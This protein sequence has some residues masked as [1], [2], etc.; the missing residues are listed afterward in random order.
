LL[1]NGRI[2]AIIAA[3]EAQRKA[4]H[5]VDA[6]GRVLLPG[7]FDMHAHVDF[8]E[9]G[10]HLAAG[11]TTVR[12]MGADNPTM[13]QIIAQEE[14]GTLLAPRIV[15]TGFIEGESPCRATRI[16]IKNVD[17]AKHAVDW[18]H[19][20]HYPQIKI[21]NSFPKDILPEVT[22]YAH[23]RGMRVGGHIPAFSRAEQAVRAGYDEIQHINQLLLNFLVDDKTDT[24]TLARFYLPPKRSRT[25]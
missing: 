1:E 22:Q 2:V 4:D 11:V 21:Y 19:E 16:V 10:L 9:G 20:H 25:D 8:W 14:A 5:V 7:L 17:E 24:R 6:A 3:G 15:P 18:Y 12:D 13:L 23:A